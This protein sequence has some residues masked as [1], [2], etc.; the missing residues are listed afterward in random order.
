MICENPVQGVKSR[1]KELL[2]VS[3]FS[4]V[5]VVIYAIIIHPICLLAIPVLALFVMIRVTQLPRSN[6]RQRHSDCFE[7][8]NQKR[9]CEDEED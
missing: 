3:V 7:R 4:V 5:L 6:E 9:G 2:I 8:Q 1:C